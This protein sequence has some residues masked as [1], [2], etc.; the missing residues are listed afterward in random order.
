LKLRGG[1]VG[2]GRMGLTHFSILNGHPNVEFVGVCD[3]SSFMLR[4]IRNYV[5]VETYSTDWELIDKAKPDFLIVA[6]PTAYHAETVRRAIDRGIHVFVEK[7]FSLSVKEGMELADLAQKKGIV[8]QVGYVVRFNEIF[9]KVRELVAG[10]ALGELLSF[11]MEMHGPTVLKASKSSWR[12]KKQEGGGVL[13]DFASHA[14]DLVNYVIG[15]PEKVTGSILQSIYSSHVE[16]AVYSTFV[17]GGGVNG[18]LLANWSDPSYRKPKYNMEVLGRNGKIIADLHMLKIFLREAPA[19]GEF[20]TGWN[21]RYLPDYAR[22][23]R[24]YVRG[25]EFTRQL[26]YFIDCILENRPAA[27]CTFADGAR[28]DRVIGLITA[29]AGEGV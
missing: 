24:F 22:P 23:V 17:H 25:N 5:G 26:D 15:E 9:E 8:N 12:S 11:K 28:T 14:I 18:R 3:S 2:F 7:P 10:G 19:G 29:D 27:V 20:S 1:V 16:D 21:A 13:Y 4:N 6:T